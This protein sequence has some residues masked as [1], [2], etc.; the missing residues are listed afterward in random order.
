MFLM[1]YTD[2]TWAEDTATQ[3][4]DRSA[5]PAA[6][7][8]LRTQAWRG[9]A[10]RPKQTRYSGWKAVNPRGLGTSVREDLM[11]VL[12]ERNQLG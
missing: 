1:V 5:D 6:G 9:G 3:G 11:D 2:F 12:I 4:C 10:S 7:M 8:R